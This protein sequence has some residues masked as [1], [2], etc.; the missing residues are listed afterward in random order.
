M[1]GLALCVPLWGAV[2]PS[3][4][5]MPDDPPSVAA[6]IEALDDLG[7][8]PGRMAAV[9]GYTLERPGGAFVLE[10]GTLAMLQPVLGRTPGAVFVGS[11]RFRFQPPSSVEQEQLQRFYETRA[12]DVEFES[13][14]FFF[15]DSTEAQLTS[16]LAF[17][18]G[19]PPGRLES[20]VGDALELMFDPG[21]GRIDT[22]FGR[23]LLSPEGHVLFDAHVEP[24]KGDRLRYRWNP[25]A[26]E[27]VQLAQRW[28]V[29]GRDIYEVISQFAMNER[30]T[31][32]ASSIDRVDH[33]GIDVWFENNLRMVASASAVLRLADRGGEGRWIPFNLYS[34]LQVDSARWQGGAAAP[35]YRGKETSSLWIWAPAEIAGQPTAV[36]NVYYR[37]KLIE[38]WEEWYVLQS[39]TGWYPTTGQVNA[40]FALTFHVPDKFEFV[41]SGTL[42]SEE[43]KGN[44]ITTQWVVTDPWIHASF[45]VGEFAEYTFH[46][47]R[48]SPIRLQ[49][50]EGAHNRLRSNLFDRGYML[51]EQQDMEEQVGQDVTLSL[52]FFGHHFG[53][54]PVDTFYVAEIFAGHGQAFPSMIQLS[55]STYQWTDKDGSDEAFRAHEVAHQWWGG[56][57]RPATYH[58]TWLSEGLAE[59]SGLW[60]MRQIRGHGQLYNNAL[61]K[62]KKN[63]LDRRGEAGPIWL[64]RRLFTSETEEDYRIITYEKGA[65]VMHMLHNL[66]RDLDGEGEDGFAAL[67]KEFHET[68]RNRM[69][70]TAD[71][72]AM[73]TQKAGADMSWFFD[74]WVRGTA[75]PT[76]RFAWTGEPTASGEYQARVRVRQ[77]DVPADFKMIIPL[78]LDF[79]EDGWAP[80]RIMVEGPVTEVDLPLMPRKPDRI[81]FNDGNAVLAEVKIEDW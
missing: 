54:I 60:Y 6:L 1:L 58:D 8:D 46:D 51:I 13:V 79:G 30:G 76:Y 75:V 18:A 78:L 66:F 23:S 43:R 16:D 2:E 50:A 34:E 19:S 48:A 52:A 67:L 4:A 11:G 22:T 29:K 14:V 74:Q 7:P 57:V 12:L 39:P 73:V 68:N 17:S 53:D 44:R 20:E 47:E 32:A 15:S 33:Y 61:E 55:W 5:T 31:G 59:F 35:F 10:S 70:T 38:E 81:V 42:Q 64:G 25:A 41:G 56:S 45:N 24:R 9:N 80:Y 21:K 27:P 71:F 69:V 26:G 72:E 62:Y 49:V 65:W 37:G 28:K 77:E 36:L 63:I 40:T 3:A